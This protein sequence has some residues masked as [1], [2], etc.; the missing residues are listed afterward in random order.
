MRY[1]DLRNLG[2]NDE[3]KAVRDAARKFTEKEILPVI[4]EYETEAKYPLDLIR[5]IG[6]LGYLGVI[7]PEKYGGAGMDAVCFACICEEVGYG[8]WVVSSAI[9]ICNSLVGSGLLKFGSEEQKRDYLV[10][11]ASGQK[12][13]SACFSEPGHGSDLSGIETTAKRDGNT[14]LLNG[15][16]VW[17]SH[18]NHADFFYVL[19][20]VDR[21]LKH[22]GI[23]VFLVDRTTPGVDTRPFP[24]HCLKRGDTGEVTFEDCRIPRENLVGEEGNGF[25]IAASCLDTGRLNVAARCVGMAQFC[26]DSAIRYSRERVQFGQ[27]IGRFQAIKH[28]IADMV[29]QTE[30]ARLMVYRLA[31]RIDEGT[32][33]SFEASMAKLFASEAAV[34]TASEGMQIFGG[35]GFASEHSIGRILME[36]KTLTVGEGT[37]EIMRD[38]IG[39]YALGY[40]KYEKSC[41]YNGYGL[42]I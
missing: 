32:R 12:L 40:K 10:P 27:E 37:S 29:T 33:A 28:K 14:Y 3:Q 5:K 11:V 20:S 1:R 35:A 15:G 41:A 9:N 4:N 36:V 8:C 26:V 31:K 21:R 30:A 42:T 24:L 7:I 38:L 17:I 39:D 34:R 2:L 16:K 19:A 18:A 22:R 25:K 6:T 13:P 23:S